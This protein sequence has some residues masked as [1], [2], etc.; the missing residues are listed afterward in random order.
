[1]FAASILVFYLS[2]HAH[3]S[4]TCLNDASRLV[5][6]SV[7]HYETILPTQRTILKM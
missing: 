5:L 4:L 6:V 2:A 1:M 7:A 3:I